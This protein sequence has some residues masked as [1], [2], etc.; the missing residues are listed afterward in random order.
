MHF[1]H[2][3]AIYLHLEWLC[4]AVAKEWAGR[5]VGSH[6]R[7]RPSVRCSNRSH[8]R[9]GGAIWT[10]CMQP[11][12]NQRA[13]GT[14]QLNRSIATDT[15]A[16]SRSHKQTLIE[17]EITTEMTPSNNWHSIWHVGQCWHRSNSILAFLY[18]LKFK[19]NIHNSTDCQCS[20]TPNWFTFFPGASISEA[21]EPMIAW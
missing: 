7:A 4:A 14:M 16:E 13:K 10:G 3:S 15:H 20:I 5:W 6:L 18:F 19:S 11:Q 8:L 21:C 9:D 17:H 12:S 2:I 1:I